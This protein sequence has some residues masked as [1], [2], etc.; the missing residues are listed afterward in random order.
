MCSYE[1]C[2]RIK[3][4]CLRRPRGFFAFENIKS[5]PFVFS[6][7]SAR[8]WPEEQRPE[9]SEFDSGL[10]EHGFALRRVGH[11]WPTSGLPARKNISGPAGSKPA[12]RRSCHWRYHFPAQLWTA[13]LLVATPHRNMRRRGGLTLVAY[14]WPVVQS[15]APFNPRC[16]PAQPAPHLPL[17][18]THTP[19]RDAS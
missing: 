15:S 12:L 2:L 1:H 18:I 3:K 14:R 19:T 7:S 17:G 5:S 9:R 16:R 6:C 11:P 13:L 10:T 8:P 4:A